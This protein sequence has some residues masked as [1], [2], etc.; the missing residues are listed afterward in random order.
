MAFLDEIDGDL[1]TWW[2]TKSSITD[3]VGTGTSAKIWPDRAKQG[4]TGRFIVFQEGMGGESYRHLSGGNTVRECVLHVYCY[5]D[6]RS[7]ASALAEAVRVATENYRGAMGSTYVHD[8]TAIA[9]DSGV[10]EP[11]DDTPQQ[12][13]WTRLVFDVTHAVTAAN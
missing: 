9:P 10:D 13:Y 8:V 1:I 7:D 4:Q 12:R 2:K 3:I 5:G 11:S 6:S